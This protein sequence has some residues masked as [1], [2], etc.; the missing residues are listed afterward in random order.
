MFHLS[1]K[2][3]TNHRCQLR[4]KAITKI[5]ICLGIVAA[6]WVL[7]I[8]WLGFHQK[9]HMHAINH[10]FDSEQASF[11][12]EQQQSIRQLEFIQVFLLTALNFDQSNY[13]QQI[14]ELEPYLSPEASHQFI[15]NVSRFKDLVLT[16]SLRQIFSITEVQT[17][18]H[19]RFWIKGSVQQKIGTAINIEAYDIE[20]ELYLSSINQQSDV[21]PY[22]I[23]EYK[24]QIIKSINKKQDSPIGIDPSSPSQLHFPCPVS[25][26]PLLDDGELVFKPSRF[27]QN[28]VYALQTRAFAGIKNLNAFCHQ[29]QFSLRFIHAK[30]G[31]NI[32]KTLFKRFHMNPA[33]SDKP[34]NSGNLKSPQQVIFKKRSHVAD[35]NNKE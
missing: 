26:A 3:Y 24:D 19:E 20:I 14:Q 4:L 28:S 34:F 9:E 10:K 2:K 1:L 32:K 12:H 22:I 11:S 21:G 35:D 15:D 29:T 6:F 16:Q 31:S 7:L 5:Y 18:D 13:N 23:T 25:Q 33:T 30:Q 8:F 27:A 17:I